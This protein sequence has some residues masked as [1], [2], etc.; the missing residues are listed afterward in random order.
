MACIFQDG[1]LI[2]GNGSTSKPASIFPSL[3]EQLVNSPIEVTTPKEV[4][5][6]Q[7]LLFDIRKLDA[8]KTPV[9]QSWHQ[10]VVLHNGKVSQ[11]EI[12]DTLF[13][14]IAPNEMY[15]CYYKTNSTFDSFY[16]REC[17]DALE[18]LF[19]K[20]LRLKTASGDPLTI[21]LRM[22]VGDIKDNQLDPLKKIHTIIN[23]GYDI[24][25]QALNLDRFEENDLFTDVICRIS[26]PRT[27][28]TMLTYAGR[29]Y[30]NNVEKLNLSYN[31]LKSTRGMHP[32]VSNIITCVGNT[33]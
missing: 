7:D 1:Q 31:G 11:A 2:R 5:S 4:F 18:S 32:T 19:D 10:V 12:L 30:T 6:A 16:V 26:V 21:T 17:F 15:P 14:G 8:Y 22:K 29:R 23:S 27:L 28:S 20:K 9:I 3:K 24:M 13:E 33:L 25:N